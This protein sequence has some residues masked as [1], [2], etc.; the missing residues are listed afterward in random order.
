MSQIMDF[1]R[2]TKQQQQQNNSLRE[3]SKF[4][5]SVPNFLSLFIAFKIPHSLLLQH[6]SQG[7]THAV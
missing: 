7:K 2:L 6:L 4:V 3:I 1:V 5:F